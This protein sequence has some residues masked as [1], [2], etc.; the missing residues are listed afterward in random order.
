MDLL[1]YGLI[2]ASILLTIAVG[3]S[4]VYGV[5]RL[6]NFAY[7]LVYILTGFVVWTFLK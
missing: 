5:S 1:I 7:G 3:F 6:A 4:L 2:N